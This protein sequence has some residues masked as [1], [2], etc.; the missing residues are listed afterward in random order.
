MLRRRE[1]DPAASVQTSHVDVLA[2]LAQL[3]QLAHKWRSGQATI[4]P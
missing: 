1:G 3:A 2:Q 4:C